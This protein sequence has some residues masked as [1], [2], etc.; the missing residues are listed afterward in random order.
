MP[1]DRPP[2]LLGLFAHPDDEVFCLGGTLA[3][4]VDGGGVG[5]IVSLTR[6]EAGEIRDATVASRRTLAAVRERELARAGSALGAAETR[7]HHYPD[8]TLARQPFEELVDVC[9]DAIDDFRPDI[10]VSFGPDGGYGHPDH[11]AASAAAT[12]AA[13]RS[14]QAPTMLHACFPRTGRLLIGLIIDWLESLDDRFRGSEAFANGLMLFANGSS[15]LGFAADHL[16]VRFYPSGTFIIEQ[17]EPPGELYL[18]LS[19]D[20]DVVHESPGGEMTRLA[21]V[22]PGCFLGE[23]GIAKGQPRN[24]NVVAAGSVTCFVLSPGR[25]SDSAGRGDTSGIARFDATDPI[26]S[27]PPGCIEVDVRSH[28][29]HKVRALACHRSQYAIS[30]DMFPPSLAEGLFGTEYFVEARR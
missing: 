29:E 6:G 21:T 24:A 7:C 1:A 5:R 20:V 9:L 28:V 18:V 10:V 17:G 12:E 8:G 4:L 15:M 27:L 2:R 26:G 23:D 19:G 13:R 30:E 22:G 3:G 11:I 16:D 25:T 14:E